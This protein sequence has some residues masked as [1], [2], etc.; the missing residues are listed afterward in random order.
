M[1]LVSYMRRSVKILILIWEGILKSNFLLDE[2]N[3]S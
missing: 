3:L 1:Y 2:K